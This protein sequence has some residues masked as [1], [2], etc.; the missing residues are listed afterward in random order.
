[1]KVFKVLFITLLFFV[2]LQLAARVDAAIS[3]D[4]VGPSSG[5]LD[6]VIAGNTHYGQAH[7]NAPYRVVNWYVKSPGQSGWGTLI[8]TDYGSSSATTSYF[9]YTFSSGSAMGDVYKI[10]AEVFPL[11]G[12]E[13]VTVPIDSD[14]ASY[15]VT[16]YDAFKVP[17]SSVQYDG[18][19][20]ELVISYDTNSVNP[21]FAAFSAGMRTVTVVSAQMLPIQDQ[22]TG[23]PP[24]E[25]GFRPKRGN[26]RAPGG[27][28]I[29]K[30]GN[31][32]KKDPSQHGGPHWDVSFPKGGH[33]NVYPPIPESPE[34]KTHGGS[35]PN[36][37]SEKRKK[38]I[39]DRMNQSSG[40]WFSPS[41][42]LT[43]AGG[44]SA[45]Y[46]IYKGGKTL[47]GIALLPT[48]AALAGGLLIVTP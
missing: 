27:G 35:T 21:A 45:G 7:I 13:D 18:D 33:V 14:S 16:V 5:V 26:A 20:N 40:S 4:Y 2:M 38:K 37:D 19:T 8:K 15:T 47:I 44:L 23:Q 9:Q 36:K 10:T 12:Q 43:V 22:D 31:K 48:P 3:V 42:L 6:T 32:W 17:I 28:W 25:S 46:L 34:W 41:Q 1:M 24:P 30:D 29:D 11:A 39:E